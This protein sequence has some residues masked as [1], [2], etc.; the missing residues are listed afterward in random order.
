MQTYSVNKFNNGTL[1]AI[2][3]IFKCFSHVDLG[4]LYICTMWADDV[5]VRIRWVSVKIEVSGKHRFGNL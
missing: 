5:G 1:L 4:K 2:F 3:A